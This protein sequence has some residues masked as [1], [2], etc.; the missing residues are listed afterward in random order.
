MF[1]A[2]G[3]HGVGKMGKIDVVIVHGAAL[4]GVA[5][6]TVRTCQGRTNR[7]FGAQHRIGTSA[8]VCN[9]QA[10]LRTVSYLAGSICQR[11]IP[12]LV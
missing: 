11:P 8:V 7:R 12:Y 10:A 5:A 6:M 1:A 9:G 4:I 3:L 2:S